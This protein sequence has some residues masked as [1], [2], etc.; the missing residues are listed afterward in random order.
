[1]SIKTLNHSLTKGVLGISFLFFMGCGSNEQATQEVAETEPVQEEVVVEEPEEEGEPFVEP[2]DPEMEEA[3]TQIAPP[4]DKGPVLSMMSTS[5]ADW[6]A[7]GNNVLDK[8]EFFGGIMQ[9]WDQDDDGSVNKEEFQTGTNEFFASYNY[10]KYG[11]FADWDTDGNGSIN[12][13]E[14]EKGMMATVTSD[15]AAEAFVTIWDTDNDDKIERVEM[16]N[17]TVRLDKDSN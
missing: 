11:R 8:S 4:R 3:V 12:D 10:K 5:Y 14:L 17:I 6:N 2:E 9:V 13:S 16:G 7:D 1:M 15:K